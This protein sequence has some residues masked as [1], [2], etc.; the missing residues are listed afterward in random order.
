MLIKQNPAFYKFVR[1]VMQGYQWGMHRKSRIVSNKDFT[2]DL[3]KLELIGR[4]NEMLVFTH[5]DMPDIVLKIPFIGYDTLEGIYTDDYLQR[6]NSVPYNLLSFLEGF[7]IM[8][9]KYYPVYSQQKVIVS[10]EVTD[11][12]FQFGLTVN[13][14]YFKRDRSQINNILLENDIR[15]ASDFKLWNIGILPDG[16]VMG[17]DLR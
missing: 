7:A 14:K 11:D 1:D 9:K 12:I 6:H 8:N 2:E 13:G 4:G 16:T 15:K 17:I 3:S 10:K 5:P